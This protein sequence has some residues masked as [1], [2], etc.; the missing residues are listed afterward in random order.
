[1]SVSQTNGQSHSRSHPALFSAGD[2]VEERALAPHSQVL[3]C[4]DEDRSCDL[5]AKHALNIAASLGLPVTF[6][7]VMETDRGSGLPADPVEWHLRLG[8]CREQLERLIEEQ[9]APMPIGRLLLTGSS[10]KELNGW[11]HDHAGA[12]LVLATHSRD[13]EQI[14]GLGGTAQ[15]VLNSGLASLLL[16]PPA[17]GDAPDVGY[18]RLLVT[19]DGS[20][21]AESI[22]PVAARMARTSGAELTL[23]HVVATVDTIE[24][25][26]EGAG[27]LRGRLRDQNEALATRYLNGL[28]IQLGRQGIRARILVESDGDPRGRLRGIAMGRT[29]LILAT[30]HGYT[31]LNDVACGSVTAY[32]A[33]H[34]PCPLLII[35]PDFHPGD[36]TQPDKSSDRIPAHEHSH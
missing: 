23:V 14:T 18:R 16:V 25:F 2:G 7:H 35:R 10:G 4:L 27:E 13:S 34:A 33:D 26:Q 9:L 21:R 17:T 24:A 30:S 29:D 6:A 36:M 12:L 32:L 20:R 5:V 1:M 31:G 15:A 8:R 19:L 28:R 11:A 3:A 22:L